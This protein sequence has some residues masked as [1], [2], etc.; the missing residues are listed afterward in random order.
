MESGQT[1]YIRV[2]SRAARRQLIALLRRT[3]E[4]FTD[5]APWGGRLREFRAIT[6]LE[7]LTLIRGKQGLHRADVTAEWLQPWTFD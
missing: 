4:G 7:Y 2:T 1:I 3:P 5:R 6:E